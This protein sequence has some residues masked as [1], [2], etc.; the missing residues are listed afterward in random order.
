MNPI[1]KKEWIK[2]LNEKQNANIKFEIKLNEKKIKV[3]YFYKYATEELKND[4][5]LNI[6]NFAKSSNASEIPDGMVDFDFIKSVFKVKETANIFQL[7]Y[8]F[9][10]TKEEKKFLKD[11][12]EIFASRQVDCRRYEIMWTFEPGFWSDLNFT[13]KIKN[14]DYDYLDLS[15]VKELNKSKI[16]LEQDYLIE[17]IN[18]NPYYLKYIKQKTKFLLPE[19]TILKY[20][21]DYGLQS[22]TKE[23][24][25]NYKVIKEAFYNYN[26]LYEEIEDKWKNKEYLKDLLN[27]Q[28]IWKDIGNPIISLDSLSKELLEDKE[29]LQSCMSY[30]ANLIDLKNKNN[31]FYFDKDL[32]EIAL[33]T[34]PHYQIIEDCLDDKN[35]V[36]LF[37][38]SIEKNNF[39]SGI[40]LFEQ[41][42]RIGE[43]LFNDREVMLE[44]ISLKNLN[45]KNFIVKNAV[46]ALKNYSTDELI[47]FIKINKE[48]YKVLPEELKNKWELVFPFYEK[49]QGISNEMPNNISKIIN[50][51]NK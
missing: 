33:K 24:K 39:Y 14:Y 10:N 27:Y 9:K 23:Q 8:E 13:R 38:K 32:K 31:K 37:I 28:Y 42:K 5:E 1:T 17:I 41:T 43:E 18:K 36:L 3:S 11:C 46:E 40:D 15:I 19:K 29:I 20:V 34:Y 50:K 7:S 44:Y 25:D 35:L 6:L 21:R 47:E 45:E 2:E 26:I 4:K 51:N 22:I 30:G 49:N 12:L 16:T 48:V